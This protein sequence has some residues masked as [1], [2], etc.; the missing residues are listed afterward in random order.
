MHPRPPEPFGE[1]MNP[2][3]AQA[4]DE[5]GRAL[6]SISLVGLLAG[7]T[8]AGWL[9]LEIHPSVQ[10]VQ[11]S[12]IWLNMLIIFAAMALEARRRPY[13]LHLM[14]LLA[15]YLFLGAPALFQYSVG[16]FA[17]AGSIHTLR[18]HITAAVYIVMIWIFFYVASYELTHSL[19]AR[20]RGAVLAFFDRPLVPA[21]T[22]F[23]LGLAF[24]VILYLGALGLAGASTRQAAR[25]AIDDFSAASAAQG[26]GLAFYL[27]HAVLLRAFSLVALLAAVLLVWKDRTSRNPFII[28]ALVAVGVGTF[29]TN[30]PFAA[31]RMWLAASVMGFVAPIVLSRFKT[32][33]GLVLCAV[34]GIT[35]LPSLHL[36]RYAADL[37][38]FWSV[39]EL[40]S[41]V[42]YL[43][44]SADGD[45]MGMLA[46]VHQWT[47]IF[48][49][50]WGMQELGASLFWVPRSLWP[51]KPIETGTMVTEGLGFE[52]TNLAPPIM[53]ETFVDFSYFGVPVVAMLM[54]FVFA[55]LDHGY[56]V[57]APGRT[58]PRVI[59]AIYP[60]WLGCVL[61]LTRGGL[62]SSLMF[63]LCFTAWIFPFAVGLSR[64]ARQRGMVE[65]AVAGPSA[66][67]GPRAGSG[68]PGLG[69]HFGAGNPPS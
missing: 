43:A 16:E 58:G 52:F 23:V 54:G 4:N 61:F 46:L 5:M 1:V 7:A 45:S 21:R 69:G 38:E 32:G 59:D 42:E 11:M 47:T 30:N 3:P 36:S 56:W 60:F 33:W 6:A 65:Q 50:R 18:E 15:L 62:F 2:A 26:Y 19:F 49:H 67:A 27:I 53:A 66:I 12:G 44:H 14:H 41:P 51:G 57:P 20:A 48:G 8:L 63:T 68:R 22:F 39:F 55:R 31:A 29:I 35:L 9:S 24:V 10:G 34:S 64:R 37:S 40:G 17:V 28:L 13:S 25:S